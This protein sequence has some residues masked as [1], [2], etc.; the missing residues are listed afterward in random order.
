MSD[1]RYAVSDVLDELSNEEIRKR[2]IIYGGPNLPVTE[3][4]RGRLLEVLREYM[5]QSNQQTRPRESK[6][7]ESLA[8]KVRSNDSNINST[9]RPSTSA[10]APLYEVI[11]ITLI[12]FQFQN[13]KV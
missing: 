12:L 9:V 8:T 2:I 10:A 13:L 6:S 11:I 1:R 7:C 3:Q 4:T 5:D